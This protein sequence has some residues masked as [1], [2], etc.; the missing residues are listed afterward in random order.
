MALARRGSATG[1]VHGVRVT[2]AEV[3]ALVLWLASLAPQQRREVSGLRPERADII[4][5]GLAVAS[6]LLERIEAE[7][8]T[9]SGF[10]LR[11]GLL[12]EMVGAV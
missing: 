11:D 6:Q 12:L 8:V 7:A 1:S 5:A 2:S 10:G 4:V 9:V 3:K